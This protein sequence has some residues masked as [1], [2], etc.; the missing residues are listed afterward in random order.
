MPLIID[1][2]SQESCSLPEAI[3]ALA[4]IQFDP[5]DEGNVKE[6]ALWLRRLTNNREFLSKY[7]VDRLAGRLTGGSGMAVDSGYGPQ[8]IVLSG[9]R[10][11]MFLRANIW[12]SESDLCFRTSGASNFVYGVPHDHNFSFLTSGYCGPGYRSDYYEYDYDTV[13][14]CPGE[15]AGLRFIERS[16]LHEGKLMLYR[17]HRDVHSQLPPQALSVSLNVMH[18]DPAQGW[19]DQYGFDLERGKVTRVL[20]PNATEA[21][22]RVA[23]ASGTDDALDYASWV[24]ETHPSE[25]LRLA[26]FEARASRLDTDGGEELWRKAE[27]SGSRMVAHVARERRAALP[28]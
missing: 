5:R 16:A 6:A 11:S 20:S 15:E 24:G 21:F 1:N 2:P 17:A 28:A 13:T 23:V 3:E 22:L 26:S 18:V 14:G 25:R 27:H 8:A 7:L 4:D 12:P 9:L 19:F 10:G